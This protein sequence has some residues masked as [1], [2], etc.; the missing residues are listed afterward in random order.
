MLK[1]KKKD[2]FG[3]NFSKHSICIEWDL[4]LNETHALRWRK[5]R[6]QLLLLSCHFISAFGEV[7][8]FWSNFSTSQ[9]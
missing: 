8:G 4:W 1:K 7:E 6:L 5:C 3:T 2:K 9:Y